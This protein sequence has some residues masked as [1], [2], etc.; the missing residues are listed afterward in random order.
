MTTCAAEADSSRGDT[1]NG[2]SSRLSLLLGA[3]QGSRD[4]LADLAMAVESAND[5]VSSLE[6]L[7]SPK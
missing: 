6:G 5:E 4:N 7:A 3:S 2:G 1:V